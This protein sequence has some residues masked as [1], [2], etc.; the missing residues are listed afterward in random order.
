MSLLFRSRGDAT[1]GELGRSLIVAP[2]CLLA[3]SAYADGALSKGS[4]DSAR[5]HGTP[6]MTVLESRIKQLEADMGPYAADIAELAG[7]LGLMRMKDGA[8]ADA[9]EAF[10]RAMHIERINGGL[11]SPRQLPF[12]DLVIE[13]SV[14]AR[15][16]EQVDRDF[17]YFEWLTHRIYGERDVAL[18]DALERIIHWHLAAIH[19]DAEATKGYHLLRLLE[20]GERKLELA[21][22]LHVSGHPALLEQLYELALHHYYVAVA[23]QRGGPAGEFLISELGDPIVYRR[24]PMQAQEEIVIESY[25][26]GRRLLDRVFDAARDTPGLPREAAGVGLT[27]LA[28]W[29]LLFNHQRRAEKI[30]AEAFNTLVAADIPIDEVRLFFS[31]PAVLPDQDF[32]LTLTPPENLRLLPAEDP[33]APRTTIRFIPWA[34]ELPGVHFPAAIVSEAIPA[35][36]DRYVVAQFRVKENG[37]A[38]NIR[39]IESHPDDR[40]LTREARNAIW[41]AQFRPRLEDGRTVVTRDVETRYLPVE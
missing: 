20:V 4:S 14:A 7:E 6:A 35:V 22:K 17:Q 39:I 21:E 30:Y 41:S 31:G 9:R 5:E 25:R 19:L 27:Y 24:S 8:S 16:W 11:Y 15:D 29:E 26:K 38:E 34:R 1:H 18:N 12:L 40:V 37:W 28:D 13:S 23:V 36:A 32:R 10:R 33:V 3:L 2:A